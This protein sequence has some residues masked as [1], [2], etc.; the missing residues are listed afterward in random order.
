MSAPDSIEAF[1]LAAIEH[2][3]GA[4]EPEV[5]G[6][7]TVLWPIDESSQIETRRLAF[8]PDAMDDAADAS[9]VTFASP[10]LAELVGLAT[11]S[12]RVARAFLPSSANP[13]RATA[14]Q[15][16]RSFRFL[17]ATWTPQTGRPWWFPAAI[18]LFRARYRADSREEELH[19][20]AVSLPDGGILRR[21]G[22]AIDRY[23]LAPEP[24]EAWPMIAE[25]PAEAAY[26]AA[27]RELERRIIAPLGLRRRELEARLG[28]ESGRAAAYYDELS[29]EVSEQLQGLPIDMPERAAL[30]SKVR[31]IRAEQEGRL[32]ELRRKYRLD[33]EVALL[34]VLRLYLPRIVF[35]GT[36]AGKREQ[37]ALALRWDPVEQA[38]EPVRCQRCQSLTY[39]IG[40]G[41]SGV[42]V[43]PHCLAAS[44]GPRGRP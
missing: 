25:L 18:F 7:Y 37:V 43:C 42:V 14:Q 22:A 27:R 17:D 23:G 33:A 6:V 21:L 1:A 39:E 13:S 29:R 2:L 40:L 3:G 5:P 35:S 32:A 26:T 38:A 30:D 4:A 11:A 41:R 10:T 36:L 8:D 19:E 12:G 34:S 31:V 24:V 9:L 44:P 16:G 15:L 28:R 20:V